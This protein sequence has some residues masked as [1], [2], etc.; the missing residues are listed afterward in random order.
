MR[1]LGRGYAHS[2]LSINASA[3]YH[4]V[5]ASNFVEAGQLGLVL[6]IKTT[7]LAGAVE[8]IEVVV[9]YAVTSKDIG[10]EM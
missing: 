6:V 9:V 4:A 10:N 5:P 1:T 3:Y 2:P 7:L 8:D